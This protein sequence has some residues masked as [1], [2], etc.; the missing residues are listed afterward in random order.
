[1]LGIEKSEY[2]L[3]A[4]F[5]INVV[6]VAVKE[7]NENPDISVLKVEYLKTGRKVSDIVFYCERVRQIQIKFDEVL[8]K[9]EEDQ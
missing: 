1:M 7:I 2:K 9:T 4:D 6:S 8:P 3:F 5:R